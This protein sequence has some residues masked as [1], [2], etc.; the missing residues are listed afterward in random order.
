MHSLI[1]QSKFKVLI[2]K[3]QTTP[4]LDI[5]TH[6]LQNRKSMQLNEKAYPIHKNKKYP[7][8]IQDPNQENLTKVHK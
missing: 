6:K 3:A 2:F 1:K 5:K 7:L 4:P 8:E